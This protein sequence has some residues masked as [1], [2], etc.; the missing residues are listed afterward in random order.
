M[1]GSIH[2]ISMFFLIC[3]ICCNSCDIE[4]LELLVVVYNYSFTFARPYVAILGVALID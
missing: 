4:S 3:I 1:I 2:N